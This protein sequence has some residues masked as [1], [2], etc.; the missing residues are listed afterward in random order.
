VGDA[1]GSLA[2][3]TVAGLSAGTIL[4]QTLTSRLRAPGPGL[5]ATCIIRLFSGG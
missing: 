5:T 2:A 4:C 3:I 1:V